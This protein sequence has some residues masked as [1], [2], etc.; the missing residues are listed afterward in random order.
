MYRER[1]RGSNNEK[2]QKIL[3]RNHI[4]LQRQ[5]QGTI[6][7]FHAKH[8]NKDNI[9]HVHIGDRTRR[10]R[11]RWATGRP[12]AGNR[13]ATGR[14]PA[15]HRQATGRRAAHLAG[16]WAIG[17]LLIQEVT[18]KI[19][20]WIYDYAQQ[21]AAALFAALVSLLAFT[22]RQKIPPPPLTAYS[23]H[24]I[25]QIVPDRDKVH[26]QYHKGGKKK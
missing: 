12:P 21:H 7:M 20:P 17:R 6:Q 15:G 23:V 19:T 14:Q 4:Q 24:A 8:N 13:Q 25:L 16:K 11:R 2:S 3:N 10:R 5:L 22:G 1:E 18:S 9:L 26:S